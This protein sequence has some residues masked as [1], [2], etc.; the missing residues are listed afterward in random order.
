MINS[1]LLASYGAFDGT[2][3]GTVLMQWEQMGFFSYLLPF[4]L[5]FALM[6]GILSQINFFDKN[7]TIN[8]LIA[9]VVSFMAMQV[10]MVSE[11]FAQ[12][13][14]RMGVGL[15]VILVTVILLGMLLPKEKWVTPTLFFV[16]VIIYVTVLVQT[17][18]SLGW[19]V[20]Q[21]FSDNLSIIVIG[22]IVI[23]FF[24]AVV[25]GGKSNGRSGWVA[26]PW[27]VSH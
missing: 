4:L 18:D 6:F 8:G 2:S 5:L 1:L 14:P 22:I 3:I 21:M 16:G 20:G 12:V 27:S 25:S 7:K 11:F 26:P 13:F 24:A 17:S 15:G 19:G 9:L 23:G 10:P